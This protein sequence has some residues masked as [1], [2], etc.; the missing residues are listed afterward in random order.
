MIAYQTAVATYKIVQAGKP[1]YISSKMKMKQ[2]D[3]SSR[4][5]TCTLIPPANKINIAREGFI[6]RGV[7]LYNKGFWENKNKLWEPHIPKVIGSNTQHF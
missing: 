1:A 6:Y 7:T 2:A 3:L 5:G 4:Q